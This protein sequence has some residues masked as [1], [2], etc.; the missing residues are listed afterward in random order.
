[1]PSEERFV[2][3]SREELASLY[4][5]NPST[6]QNW[7]AA[8]M[9]GSRG[10][11]EL[12]EVLPWR[13]KWWEARLANS[14]GDPMLVS[15]GASPALEKYREEKAALARMDRL[16]REGNLLKSDDLRELLLPAFAVLRDCGER[17]QAMF[18]AD[19]LRIHNEAVDAAIRTVMERVVDCVGS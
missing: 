1:M 10:H 15:D 4:G 17:L 11:W 6:I 14:S 7:S 12:R 2:A 3:T 9:P 18:G 13:E 19:A 16:E 8:G 5:K